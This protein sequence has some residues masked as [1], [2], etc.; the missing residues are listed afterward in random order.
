MVLPSL[1]QSKPGGIGMAWAK[2][3]KQYGWFGLWHPEIILLLLI[4]WV[5]YEWFRRTHQ[6]IRF[7]QYS[8]FVAGIGAIY[9][10][11]GTPL[12]LLGDAYLLTAHMV[13]YVLLSMAV[14]PLIIFG[15]PNSIWEWLWQRKWLNTIFRIITYPPL[16]LLLFNLVFSGLLYPA[17]LDLSL[18]NTWLYLAAPYGMLITAVAMWWPLMSPLSESPRLSRGASLVY[19]FFGLDLM[20]PASV[21]IIDTGRPDY[22]IYREAPRLFHLSA[23]ADQQLGG[24]VMSIGMLLAYAVAFIATY[25][26]YDDSHWYE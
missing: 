26:G 9:A 14:P 7:A 10:S 2:I 4:V 8:S 22:W 15:V 23:L 12:K 6:A 21:Y 18:R 5:L 20:M 17:V 11:M 24:I 25:A 13:Q 19:L 16:A 1:S 3:Q